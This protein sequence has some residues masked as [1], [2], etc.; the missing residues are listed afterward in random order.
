[1]ITSSNTRNIISED[2]LLGR[3]KENFLEERLRKALEALLGSKLVRSEPRYKIYFYE[4]VSEYLVPWIQRLKAARLAELER[5][6]AQHNL[7][8]AKNK[9]RVL[10]KWGMALAILSVVL[11]GVAIF[12]FFQRERVREHLLLQREW[13]RKRLFDAVKVLQQQE[14]YK[15]TLPD[16]K[17]TLP[18]GRRRASSDTGARL[19]G[20]KYSL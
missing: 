16:F 5:I 2:D 9:T 7:A 6:K 20:Q 8:L 13:D 15:K 12:F 10:Q 11:V 17:R 3:E 4:I 1:M 18:E 19:A 14:I